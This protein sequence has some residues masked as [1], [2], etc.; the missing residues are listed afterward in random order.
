MSGGGNNRKT[1]DRQRERERERE[2]ERGGGRM[3][4]SCERT[5]FLFFP[6]FSRVCVCGFW[7]KRRAGQSS[8]PRRK[9]VP[10]RHLEDIG[11]IRVVFLFR[12][13]Y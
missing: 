11:E 7:G 12:A 4:V 1:T 5:H 13:I 3:K 6:S 10:E 2:R 8:I 9:N